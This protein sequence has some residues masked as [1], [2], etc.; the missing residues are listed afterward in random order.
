M[1]ISAPT[2]NVAKIL[3]RSLRSSI[4]YLR[5][6]AGEAREKVNQLNRYCMLK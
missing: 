3:Q 4:F 2:P 5:E 1:A 6:K